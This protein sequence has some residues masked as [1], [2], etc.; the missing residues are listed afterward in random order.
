MHRAQ[1]VVMLTT[2]P[3]CADQ[4]FSNRVNRSLAYRVSL[5]NRRLL[6]L[7]V[8]VLR[9]RD[10]LQPAK[11]LLVSTA[12][13]EYGHIVSDTTRYKVCTGK[14]ADKRPF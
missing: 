10:Q 14:L 12:L 11:Q 9:R 3:C 6:G 13:D 5:N 8:Y 2:F 4:S 7:T 1:T